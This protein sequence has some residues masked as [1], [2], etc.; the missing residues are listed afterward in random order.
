[1]LSA[2]LVGYKVVQMGQPS[3][4][5]LLAP[6]GMMEAF[7]HEQLP[8]ECGMR[9]IEQGA[10]HRPLGVCEHGRPARLVVLEPVSYA[11]ASGRSSRGGD[12][13]GN[14]AEPLPQCK[15]PQALALARP[16]KQGVERQASGLAHGRRDRCQVLGELGER[17]AQA[18]A[19]ACPR[20]QR[21]QAF[22]G[23]VEPIG[24]NPPDPLRRLL[25]DR[26]ASVRRR[27]S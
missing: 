18:V 11:L 16:V 23:A 5:R 10:G 6:V 3:Q 15:H 26:R 14:V 9:L 25:V 24:Q 21:T 1:M 27:D 17:V 19:E 4:K 13:I 12:V 22:G 7:H 2:P 8:V 20:E